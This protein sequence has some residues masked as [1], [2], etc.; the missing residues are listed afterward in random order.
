MTTVGK[1]T[2]IYSG[3]APGYLTMNSTAGRW[4]RSLTK[5]AL[6]R[7]GGTY[8][9]SSSF[10]VTRGPYVG[11]RTLGHEE[12]LDG[13]FVNLLDP[14]LPIVEDPLIG[15]HGIGFYL[16]AGE[17]SGNPKLLA[18]AGRLRARVEEPNQTSFM[19][20]APDGKTGAARIWRGKRVLAGIKAYDLLGHAIPVSI[21]DSVE[22]VL[23]RY[24]NKAD[25]VIVR[26]A[27]R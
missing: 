21:E 18:A 8:R 7:A 24:D 3:V 1:G 5:L 2:V 16:D 6:D 14:E 22:S 12:R 27:W 15:R 23:V 13:R 10:K 4:I 17:A 19:V 20:Q 11:V 25:G 26:A 9:E